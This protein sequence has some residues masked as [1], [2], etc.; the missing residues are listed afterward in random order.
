[1]SWVSYAVKHSNVIEATKSGQV[2][3]IY[4]MQ[5]NVIGCFG[6]LMFSVQKRVRRSK[7]VSNGHSCELTELYVGCTT[8]KKRH[9]K[10]NLRSEIHDISMHVHKYHFDLIQEAIL[11]SIRI[12]SKVSS[13]ENVIF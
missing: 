5:V 9:P 12:E 13:I 2:M 4:S 7:K 10:S 1:M 6:I 11:I 8:L 3:S